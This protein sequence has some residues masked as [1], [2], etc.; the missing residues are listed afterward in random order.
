[1][2]ATVAA[3][4]SLSPVAA[5]TALPSGS[6]GSNN[7]MSPE[8]PTTVQPAKEGGT[9][10]W[11]DQYIALNDEL[12]NDLLVGVEG[13]PAPTHPIAEA[14]AQMLAPNAI[15]PGKRRRV[16]HSNAQRRYRERQKEKMKSLESEVEALRDRVRELETQNSQLVSAP[17]PS[18]A[19]QV[20]PAPASEKDE[21]L[22]WSNEPR[23]D[24]LHDEE[25]VAHEAWKSSIEELK[26]LLS[27]NAEDGVIDAQLLRA[28]HFC[29][30]YSNVAHHGAGKC[31]LLRSLSSCEEHGSDR[32]DMW[33]GIAK[34]VN[35]NERTRALMLSWRGMYLAAMQ[36]VFQKREVQLGKLHALTSSQAS[37]ISNSIAMHSQAETSKMLGELRSNLSEQQQVMYKYVVKFCMECFSGP[38]EK[39]EIFVAAYPI[40]FDPLAFVNALHSLHEK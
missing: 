20:A 31:Y 39:G 15:A 10:G 32:Y 25:K 8:P 28:G 19:F 35:L 23:E 6:A 1:M 12:V 33:I 40:N 24:E 21:E 5:A 9:T 37:D 26:R 2:A 14:A 13:D 27:S 22:L 3:A 30:A 29:R 11:L 7:K 17:A 16:E 38:R 4:T 36:D 18:T 34:K